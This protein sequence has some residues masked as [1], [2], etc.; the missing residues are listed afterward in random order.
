[1]FDKAGMRSD[2]ELSI[3]GY[4]LRAVQRRRESGIGSCFWEGEPTDCSL[5]FATGNAFRFKFLDNESGS[6]LLSPV[7]DPRDDPVFRLI[8]SDCPQST[9]M[10]INRGD[11]SS[12]D[13]FTYFGRSDLLRFIFSRE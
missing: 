13:Q 3:D 7:K 2:K 11:S 1:M 4:R 6:D 5:P 9:E 8:C 10:C 12:S